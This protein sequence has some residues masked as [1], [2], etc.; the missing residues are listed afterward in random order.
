MMNY[1]EMLKTGCIIEAQNPVNKYDSVR[2]WIDSGDLMG[3][4]PVHEALR[5][6]GLPAE[7]FEQHVEGLLE[8]ALIV[9]V[10]SPDGAR[11]WEIRHGAQD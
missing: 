2:Y 1:M 4:T 11:C 9:K 7:W 10:Y 6:P 8:K 3:R 5:H